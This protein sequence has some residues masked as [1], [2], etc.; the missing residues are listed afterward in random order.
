M[1]GLDSAKGKS[2]G[3]SK[4][5]G[6]VVLTKKEKRMQTAMNPHVATLRA[7][8]FLENGADRKTGRQANRIRESRGR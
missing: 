6:G 5:G 8:L 7:A 1:K 3:K 2:G 4:A